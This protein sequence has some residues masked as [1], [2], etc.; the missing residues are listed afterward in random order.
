MSENNYT[1]D[2]TFAIEHDNKKKKRIFNFKNAFY[3]NSVVCKMN[4]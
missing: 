3:D 1:N 2:T 4:L